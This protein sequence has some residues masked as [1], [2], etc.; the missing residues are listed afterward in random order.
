MKP[1][2]AQRPPLP[3]S[4]A[5]IKLNVPA[6][7]LKIFKILVTVLVVKLMWST[8][9][10]DLKVARNTQTPRSTQ[11]QPE[12]TAKARRTAEE[13]K[14]ALLVLTGLEKRQE[15]DLQS[16]ITLKRTQALKDSETIPRDPAYYN[17][18]EGPKITEEDV[19][20]VQTALQKA[21]RIVHLHSMYETLTRCVTDCPYDQLSQVELVLQ[22]VDFQQAMIKAVQVVAASGWLSAYITGPAVSLDQLAALDPTDTTP[23][24]Q[25]L[26]MET[27][28]KLPSSAREDKALQQL[29]DTIKK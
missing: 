19:Q 2:S 3:I 8:A 7:L 25:S 12:Q 16:T 26:F 22:L 29:A 4:D 5:A 14:N 10:L 1:A 21:N 6:G 17:M 20:Q 13:L 11:A 9:G 27:F 24:N 28:A 23:E 15:G 18:S